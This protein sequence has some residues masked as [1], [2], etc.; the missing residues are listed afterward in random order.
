MDCNNLV[1]GPLSVQRVQKCE[2]GGQDLYIVGRGQPRVRLAAG[3]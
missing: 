1:A 3:W 2:S